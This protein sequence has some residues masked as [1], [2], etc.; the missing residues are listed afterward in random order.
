MPFVLGTTPPG[1]DRN[2]RV[3]VQ[4]CAHRTSHPLPLSGLEI[5]SGYGPSGRYPV[6]R[7]RRISECDCHFFGMPILQA[8]T[9]PA[10]LH[11]LLV[12]PLVSEIGSDHILHGDTHSLICVIPPSL[13]RPASDQEPMHRV[14]TC[15]TPFLISK[16]AM[17]DCFWTA[18]IEGFL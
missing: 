7:I 1:S 8:I 4:R 18:L 3:V 15:R 11:H 14:V 10:F 9:R 16:A 12:W 6:E 13:S 17:P 5:P 2:I